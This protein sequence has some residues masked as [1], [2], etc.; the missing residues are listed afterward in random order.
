MKSRFLP[1]MPCT[2]TAMSRL[3]VKT[4]KSRI[5]LKQATI[6]SPWIIRGATAGPISCGWMAL[7]L[8][9]EPF[10]KSITA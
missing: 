8:K 7:S 6:C 4:T 9:T 3:F 10:E 1:V 2:L 5:A